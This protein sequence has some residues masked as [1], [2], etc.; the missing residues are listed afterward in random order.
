MASVT[1]AMASLT[2]A[3][4]AEAV[5]NSPVTRVLRRSPVGDSLAHSTAWKWFNSE[6]S[7]RSVRP[8]SV[9]VEEAKTSLETPDRVGV[10][11]AKNPLE[12]YFYA[13]QGRLIHK[14]VHY[15]EIYHRHFRPFRNKPVT[16]VEFG[17]SQGGSLQMWKHYF[18]PEARIIGVDINPKCAALAEPQIQIRIGDQE[19]RSFLRSLA[20]EVGG[21][22]VLIEDGGHT[23]GQQIATFEE[24]W[25]NIVEG[26][27]FLI[28]DLHTS[29]LP[30]YGGGLRRE[31]TFIEY[32]KK[33]ID[34]EHAWYS[35]ED[36]LTV[37]QYTKTIRGMH[38]YDSIIVFDKGS[39]RRPKPLKTG[40]KSD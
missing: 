13:N 38:V 33:L 14:W 5:R 1:K 35:R 11:E 17:V 27:V 6:R 30:K 20:D 8:N 31:G 7:G 9:G 10:Q 3:N 2:K 25:P 40:T 18:G 21:I 4:V 39:V 23:M 28:E 32:A 26:G 37:D 19:D 29:Y 36:A 15:F 12:T 16:I 24:M 34:Q 22:D